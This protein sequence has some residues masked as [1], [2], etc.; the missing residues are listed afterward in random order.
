MAAPRCYRAAPMT[1]RDPAL[2]AECRSLLD[3]VMRH[4]TIASLHAA[5]EWG[6][7][8]PRL[9]TLLGT[10]RLY[11][12]AVPPGP[13]RDPAVV[14]AVQWNIEHGNWYDQVERALQS[15]PALADDDLVFCNEIDLGCARSGNRD[16]T[17]DLC[18]ALG[19]HGAWAPLYLESTSGRDD[20]ARMA[21]GRDNEEALFGN[22]ILSRW[23]LADV[24]VLPLPSPES[25]QFDVERMIGRHAAVIATVE[26]P[27]APFV[28]VSA[29]LEVHRTRA[30]RRA[31]MHHV[32]R[33][34][35]G[36]QR[37]VI[38][39]G[40]FNTHTFDRGLWH[41]PLE[42]ALALMLMP[43]GPL[44]RRFLH[45]DHGASRETLFDELALGGFEWAPFNDH[46]PT[47]QL[48]FDRLDELRALFG[49]AEGLARRL[50]AWVERRARL[51]LDWF[52]GRGWAGGH[53]VTAQGFDG[54]GRASDHAPIAAEFH[55]RSSE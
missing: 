37:P 14:R 8:S 47:L 40:D 30:H 32:V 11:R 31:Q 52:A 19:Y 17:A 21:A 1:A 6:A 28:A 41:A 48:R 3:A 15:D 43:P 45:P 55:S 10:P 34:L 22:A 42:G 13:P 23:P 29:H 38:L 20:D 44:E 26:R 5:S 2:L 16:V 33:A 25:I 18:A 49:P 46:Q 50:L 24:R 53:G 27:G 35:A 39:A 7:L 51:R 54:P 36:E 9:E 12:P 4:P